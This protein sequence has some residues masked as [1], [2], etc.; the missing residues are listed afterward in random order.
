MEEIVMRQALRFFGAV[1]IM[2]AFLL[3]AVSCDATSPAGPSEVP[4]GPGP[5][6]TFVSVV[7]SGP[8]TMMTGTRE[9]FK[10]AAQYSDNSTRDVTSQ[11]TWSSS[12]PPFATV[13]PT[14][15]V[16]AVKP[17]EPQI[18]VAFQDKNGFQRI[19]VIPSSG[20][21][22][23]ELPPISEAAKNFIIQHNLN[24]LTCEPCS[25]FLGT[26]KRWNEFPIT[27]YADQDFNPLHLQDAVDFWT[28]HTNGK[29]TFQIVSAPGQ[30]ILDFQWPPPNSPQVPESSCG[31][32][33]PDRIINSVIISG[34]GH[35]AFKAKPQCVGNGNH[36]LGLAHGIGHILGILGHTP[37]RTDVMSGISVWQT[38]PLL[39]EVINW[40][41][42]VEPG[43]RPE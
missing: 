29:V 22:W 37:D 17:G 26:V 11:S 15:M 25:N 42:S 20:T 24:A 39:S 1:L 12:A 28:R 8:A 35:Y 13:S 7:V 30:I 14:G 36:T 19:T 2:A 34:A 43:V 32:E 31:V 23:S 27:V 38:S 10:A 4:P 21:P 41:Y 40:L 16:T 33:A 3:P 18:N 6:S 5:N 9:Q